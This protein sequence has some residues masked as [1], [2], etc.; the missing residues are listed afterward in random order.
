MADGTIPEP[1][2]KCL[3]GLGEWLEVNGE[4]IFGTRPWKKS[5]SITLD[6]IEV[7]Y[8]HKGNLLY[9]IILDNPKTNEFTIKDLQIDNI[10][11]IELLGHYDDLSWIQTNGNLKITFPDK[12]EDAPAYSLKILK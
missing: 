12:L 1:Q 5:Q 11:K 8:T 4:A 10:S 9:I 3:L 7:R 6:D 2:V